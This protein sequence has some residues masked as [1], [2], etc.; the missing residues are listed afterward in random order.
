MSMDRD[1][2]AVPNKHSTSKEKSAI[3]P[4]NPC[5]AGANIL[6]I[7]LRPH[8]LVLRSMPKTH[9]DCFPPEFQPDISEGYCRESK[10][11]I[12]VVGGVDEEEATIRFSDFQEAAGK[13]LPV[14][15]G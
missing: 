9:P 1:S 8:N 13:Q 5:P 2:V 12:T 14:F 15:G 6:F 7:S 4:A 11:R 10:G 3:L